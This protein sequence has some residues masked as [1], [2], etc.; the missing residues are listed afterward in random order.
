MMRSFRKVCL[1]GAL[2]MAACGAAVPAVA[3]D[4]DA[5]VPDA[6]RQ[7]TLDIHKLSGTESTTRADG[8]ALAPEEAAKYG[9][10]MGGVV[11]DVY[12]VS[13]IDFST[14]EGLKVAEKIYERKVTAADV[15]AGK[16]SVDGQDYALV[17]EAQS[18]T[19]GDD[20]SGQ[21]TYGLGIYVVAENLA[22]STPTVDGTA[23]GKDKVTPSAPFLVSLP[24]TNP[25][26]RS[27]WMYDVNVYPK[28]QVDEITKSVSDGK[29]G[30]Q[31]Q[32]GY[33][34]GEKITY[35]LNST[36]LVGD[37]NGDGT[38]DGA[39]FGGV[40]QI[41]DTL[42]ANL[43]FESE[44]V[45][46]T[47]AAGSS[48]VL[49]KGAD[50]TVTSA[51]NM[52]TVSMT[53]QGLTKLAKV[54]GG[55]V[56][57]DLVARVATM[58]ANGIVENQAAF[59]P[60]NTWKTS[61]PE[62]GIFSNK[63]V[64]K[65]GDI[66]IHKTNKA[67]DN[68]S[69]AVFKVFRATNGATCDVEALKGDPVATSNP[70]DAAGLTK[71]AGLQLSNFYDGAEQA[72]LHSYCMVESTAPDGYTLLAKPVKFDLTAAGSVTDLSAALGD[73]V[74]ADAEDLTG[75]N[76]HITNV[77]KGELPLT[78]AQG[79]ALLATISIILAGVGTSLVISS[80][81]KAKAAEVVAD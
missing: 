33:R 74:D 46:L 8:T 36:V 56:T 16:I 15:A 81:K 30:T 42:D 64:S 23:V 41:T 17:K 6:S 49:S 48:E 54:S 13:G 2:T 51:N 7:A 57:T 9:K 1:A 20:G 43:S 70:T 22:N 80:R 21:G 71:L 25:N 76:V 28:N 29:V 14:N 65:Y 24:M 68:L 34:I 67:G 77:K 5:V 40:Y 19:T 10:P 11:F 72:N 27:E 66:V 32:D 26:G 58:P 18:V 61:H 62:P 3:A 60:N 35:S 39:D 37:K 63:V 55:S 52:V 31:D 50:Y 38:V 45:T 75:R 47:S 69:G 4:N 44:T 12:K 59:V 79:V 73:G 53:E 78:G